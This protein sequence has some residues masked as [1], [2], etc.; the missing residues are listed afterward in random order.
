M[1]SLLARFAEN[2]FWLARYMERAENLARILDVNETFA[3]DSRGPEDWLPIVHLHA[4]D[5]R[6]FGAHAAATAEAVIHFYVLDGANPT[7]IISAVRMAREN[8]RS[9][10][11][12]ISTEMWRHLNV[13]YNRLVGLGPADLA[14]SNLSSL[15]ATIKEDCQLH[16]GI[17]E[18]TYYR[19]QGWY[20]YHLGKYLERADQTTRLL[21]INTH[22]LVPS[23]G[24]AGTGADAS[25]WNAVLRSAA[26]YHAFRRAYPSG[27][28]PAKV[29]QFLL[30]DRGFPR[31][32]AV[33]V[34]EM[35]EL[36]RGLTSLPDLAGAPVRTGA[37][38]ALRHAGEA[39]DVNQVLTTGLHEF[40]DQL[41]IQLIRLTNDLGSTF[42]GHRDDHGAASQDQS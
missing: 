23:P 11:H 42:F 13:F 7:S 40:L 20:F 10:R 18:G 19:D 21:D 16:A 9:L 22:R 36:F 41:Q 39:S 3:Q 2:N 5:A 28:E 24:A 1:P 33:C 17:V 27:M 26:G 35:V 25:Q 34:R 4:D 30:F 14:L 31:S 37:L 32:V 12:L 38:E 15:C 29:A 8:A 6:F